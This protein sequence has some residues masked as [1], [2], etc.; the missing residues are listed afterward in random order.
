LAV[1]CNTESFV[2]GCIVSGGSWDY[3]YSRLEDVA[4][5]LIDSQ[6]ADR[7]ALGR[8]LMKASEAL[9]DIEWVDSG[10]Y[11][12]GDDKATIAAAL[13]GPRAAAALELQ[14]LIAEGQR[15][16]GEIDSARKRAERAADMTGGAT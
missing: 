4:G 7:R 8:M 3:F 9:H 12:P 2:R 10:D 6:Q 5:R 16:A 13:G 11:G 1:V 14:E 15:I